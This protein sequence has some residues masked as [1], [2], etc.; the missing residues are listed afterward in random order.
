MESAAETEKCRWSMSIGMPRSRFVSRLSVR[1]TEAAERSLRYNA[2]HEFGHVL[3]F[4][5][6]Q[7]SARN[8]RFVRRRTREG[9]ELPVAL[10]E[11]YCRPA[12]HTDYW[13]YQV[14]TEGF[15]VDL[16]MVQ[17]YCRKAHRAKDGDPWIPGRIRGTGVLSPTDIS[18]AQSI[19][20]KPLSRVRQ[21]VPP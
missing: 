13:H 1:W 15:D 21:R 11:I 10:E 3:G 7:D 6:E 4:V 12:V 9:V 8:W 5:H 2:V 18:A 16:I 19:Y 20:G 17:G 14:M